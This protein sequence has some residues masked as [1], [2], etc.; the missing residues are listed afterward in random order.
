MSKVFKHSDGFTLQKILPG[1]TK[2]PSV[3]ENLAK[4]IENVSENDRSPAEQVTSQQVQDSPLQPPP[5]SESQDISLEN[6]EVSTSDTVSSPPIDQTESIFQEEQPEPPQDPIDI[7]AIS[8]EYYNK[9]IQD[10]MRNMEEDYLSS[11]KSLMTICEEMNQI[12]EIILNNSM[13][14]MQNLVFKIAEKIIRFSVTEQN[15]TI[16]KTVEEAIRKAVKSDEFVIQ[17]NPGD[18]EVIND[19]SAELV[20]SLSGLENIVFK[21][22]PSIER[23]GCKIES[24]NCTVDATIDNQLELIKGKI[25]KNT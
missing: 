13:G 20:N 4:P 3:W 21:A 5:S 12:R 17:V 15:E 14:E 9:G 23:G 1:N 10:C 8:E 18:F 24:D 16:N 19:K 6:N 11:T 25:R 7:E 22:D 2:R